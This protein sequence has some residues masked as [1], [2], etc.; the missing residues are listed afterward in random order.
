M[1]KSDRLPP[2][3][4]PFNG[5][6][7]DAPAWFAEALEQPVET[8]AAERDG[9]KLA[10]K[11]WGERGDPGLVLIHGGTAHKGWWDAI[12]P[13]LAQSG[14]RVVA[15]DIA[16]MGESGWR[17]VYAMAE[18]AADM[19][20]AATDAGAFEAG[21]PVFAGHSFGGFVTLK[22]A[23]EFGD[24]LAGAIVMDSPIRPLDQQ[25]SGNPPRHGGRVYPD[26]AAA[27]ARFRLLPEQECE[28]IWLVD[29]IARGSLKA[30]EGGFTWLFD[31]DLW[32]KLTYEPRDPD[33]VA[34]E[35]GCPLAFIRG[36]RSK[37]MQAETWDF[38]KSKFSG[39]PFVSVP[40]AEHHLI[41]DQ[42]LA[43]VAAIEALVEGWAK[44]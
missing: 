26:L 27:L 15:P 25:R 7:P 14:R 20:A 9:I 37:L 41:L 38:M 42:P 4:A 3:L 6:A 33:K 43:A 32:R 11:A 10:W 16:G 19:R 40:N 21:K 31:P 17:D 2:P 12:G 39:A 13:F 30:V 23:T 24:A 44:A 1:T 5:A 35:A 34:A 29:H 18:H 36:A 28:K 22:A 8:G